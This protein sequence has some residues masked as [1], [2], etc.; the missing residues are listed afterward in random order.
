MSSNATLELLV[1][2]HE[3]NGD[4]AELNDPSPLDFMS[5]A[6]SAEKNPQDGLTYFVKPLEVT[7]PFSELLDHLQDRR[8]EQ[9]GSVVKYSQAR[10]DNE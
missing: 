6:D 3:L 2:Y 9:I 8:P 1:T 5:N 10:K 7:E 4:I